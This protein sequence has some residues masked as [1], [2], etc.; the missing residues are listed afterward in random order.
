M[1]NMEKDKYFAPP[2]LKYPNSPLESA[3]WNDG[4]GAE[5]LLEYKHHV[6]EDDEYLVK[7]PKSIIYQNPIEA[8]DNLSKPTRDYLAS[9]KKPI[10]VKL[11]TPDGKA[12]YHPKLDDENYTVMYDTLF[13]DKSVI[14]IGTEHYHTIYEIID[15]VK[16]DI[17]NLNLPEDDKKTIWDEL[18]YT[19]CLNAVYYKFV[20]E[21]KFCKEL[22]RTRNNSIFCLSDNLEYGVKMNDDGTFTGKNYMGAVIMHV[23][24]E[25]NKVYENYDEIDW[26]L[27]GGANSRNLCNCLLH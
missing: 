15:V 3:F 11:W 18:E 25:I 6:T 17:M 14:P 26:E 2:W 1:N 12:I 8:S 27:S 21:I 23:R 4:N 7:F 19:V 20:T 13:T 10:F 16:E 5:Y 24:D 9:N 22:K